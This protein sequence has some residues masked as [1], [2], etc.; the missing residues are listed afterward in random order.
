MATKKPNVG[1]ISADGIDGKV[2]ITFLPTNRT[3][4][5]MPLQGDDCPTDPDEMVIQGD[6]TYSL[7]TMFKLVKPKVDVS[8]K[9]GD[10]KNPLQDET[11]QFASISDFEPDKIVDNVPLLRNLKDQ[12]L[13]IQKLETLM[14]EGAFQRLLQ[15]K[16]QKPALIGFLRSVIA[17]IEAQEGDE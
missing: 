9:T 12:Q 15:N 3:L 8:L 5:M 6:P 1:A 7:E 10:D 13:L 11:I 17:D 4:L 2:G 14:Q 16:S